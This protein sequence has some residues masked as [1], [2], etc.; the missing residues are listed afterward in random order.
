MFKEH[1]FSPVTGELVCAVCRSW[2]ASVQVHFCECKIVCTACSLSTK[3]CEDCG[4]DFAEDKRFSKFHERLSR[5]I[6]RPCVYQTAGCTS[7]VKPGDEHESSCEFK[8]FFC[9]KCNKEMSNVTTVQH[10]ES[11]HHLTRKNYDVKIR[12]FYLNPVSGKLEV[13]CLPSRKQLVYLILNKSE[14]G[15]NAQFLVNSG[16]DND[17]SVK[18]VFT[19]KNSVFRY[20]CDNK[21]SNNN[22]EESYDRS[23]LTFIDVSNE[24][25]NYWFRDK[26]VLD[27]SVRSRVKKRKDEKNSSEDQ[28]RDCEQINKQ[29][30]N[31]EKHTSS[32]KKKRKL[33]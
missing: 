29:N 30:G 8:P 21:I 3:L 25:I 13:C 9:F 12:D 28:I 17:V 2:M 33:Q 31:L 20:E 22:D 14:E 26:C 24:A 4:L 27:I 19:K 6:G 10:F 23:G 11:E 18:L 32:D 16:C 1:L 15:E 5:W 7:F